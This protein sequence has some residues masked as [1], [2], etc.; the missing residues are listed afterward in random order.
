MVPAVAID[1]RFREEDHGD[2]PGGRVE[3]AEERGK[4]RGEAHEPYV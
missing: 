4:Q 2:A 1:G 3:S